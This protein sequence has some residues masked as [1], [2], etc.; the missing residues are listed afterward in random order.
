M[1]FSVGIA[2]RIRHE[3]ATGVIQFGERLRISELSERYGVSTMP[4]REAFRRLSGEGFIVHEPNRTARVQTI[5]RRYLEQLFEMHLAVETVL[6]QSAAAVWKPIDTEAVTAIH[7]R[8]I[9][10]AEAGEW[11]TLLSLNRE[12]H[13]YIYRRADL[14]EA[15]Q[16][17]DRHWAFTAALWKRYGYA[18]DR[19]SGV[20]SDH[21]HIII[22]LSDND[23]L[24]ARLLVGA[25]VIKAR[26]HMFQ[27]VPTALEKD[28][29]AKKRAG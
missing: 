14:P 1:V 19:Y 18:E 25:H 6:T 24:S 22:A 23:V 16:T 9:D 15:Y 11:E 5:S 29:K 26:N 21:E 3:I 20:I 27:V 10:A 8:L 28:G 4:I 13:D 2:D 12:F 17:I 7:E